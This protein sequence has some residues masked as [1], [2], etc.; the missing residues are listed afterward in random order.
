VVTSDVKR[1]H[2]GGYGRDQHLSEKHPAP[3]GGSSFF[4]IAFVSSENLGIHPIHPPVTC[5]DE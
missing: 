1:L 3:L 5:H 4:E 2:K